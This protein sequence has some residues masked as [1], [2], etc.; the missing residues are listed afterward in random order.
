MFFTLLR[1]FISKGIEY[2]TYCAPC[3]VNH[4]YIIHQKETTPIFL[5]FLDLFLIARVGSLWL[6]YSLVF[7]LFESKWGYLQSE[8]NYRGIKCLLRRR[9]K[10]VETNGVGDLVVSEGTQQGCQSCQRKGAQPFDASVHYW[11]SM[12]FSWPYFWTGFH[13]SSFLL[14][15]LAF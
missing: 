10:Q 12:Q 5:I 11:S 13:P 8:F 2:S 6:E 15:P 4:K 1:S 9:Q 7:G 3:L 14:K